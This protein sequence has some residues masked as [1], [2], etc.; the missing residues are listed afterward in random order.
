MRNK[1]ILFEFASL[2]T[3]NFFHPFIPLIFK[4][5]SNF[6]LMLFQSIEITEHNTVREIFNSNFAFSEDWKKINGRTIAINWL[7]DSYEQMGDEFE[8]NFSYKHCVVIEFI[9]FLQQITCL[10]H[11]LVSNKRQGHAEKC[12][13]KYTKL[14]MINLRMC[15]LLKFLR[16]VTIQTILKR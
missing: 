14:S 5:L 9:M 11:W 12:F 2:Q 8:K 7:N 16:I 3:S 6:N 4:R 1:F 15:S 13:E 10:G